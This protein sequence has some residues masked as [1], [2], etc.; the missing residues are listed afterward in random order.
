ML[1]P[2]PTRVDDPKDA[3]LWSVYHKLQTIDENAGS[4]MNFASSI[5]YNNHVGCSDSLFEFELEQIRAILKIEKP[6][7]DVNESDTTSRSFEEPTT[8][9]MM[10]DL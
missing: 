4:R 3:V 1:T 7:E 8:A 6:K 9:Q 10:R 5:A 2:I